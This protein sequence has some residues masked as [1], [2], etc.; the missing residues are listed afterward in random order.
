LFPFSL[1][2]AFW[3]GLAA[4][5]SMPAPI[6]AN[7]VETA[8]VTR[9]EL[10]MQPTSFRYCCKG[11][12]SIDQRIALPAGRWLLRV[13]QKSDECYTAIHPLVTSSTDERLSAAGVASTPEWAATLVTVPAAV[14]DEPIRVRIFV[15]GGLR[16]CGTTTIN[17]VEL[18]SLG[19]R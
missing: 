9:V 18:V 6:V 12:G 19:P 15:E 1:A 4:C 11:G 17:T 10:P 2:R 3:L 8:P 14:A 13:S 16:C 5:S 7:T